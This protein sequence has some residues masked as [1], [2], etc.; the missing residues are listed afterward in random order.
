MSSEGRAERALPTRSKL[1]G[2]AVGAAAVAACVACCAAPIAGILAA[3]GI[4][5]G[6]AGLLLPAL[7]GLAIVLGIAATAVYLRRRFRPQSTSVPQPVTIGLP[8]YIDRSGELDCAGHST[9]SLK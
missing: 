1:T 6:V 3:A 4:A 7:W 2:A 8:T 5:S 9:E